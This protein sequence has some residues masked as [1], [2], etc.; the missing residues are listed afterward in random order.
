MRLLLLMRL[1]A[2]LA[3]AVAGG[4]VFLALANR[5]LIQLRQSRFKMFVVFSVMAAIIALSGLSGWVTGWTAWLAL[6][7]LVI[8]AA[9]A[10]EGFRFY[11]RA[12]HRASR[13]SER[14]RPRRGW[15]VLTTTDCVLARYA[16]ALKGWKGK[17][18]TIAHVSDLH[19]D[20]RLG[21]DYFR[22]VADR[23]V[24][25]QPDLL[26]IAGD[27]VPSARR[28]PLLAPVLSRFAPVPR[29]YA[30]LG[31]HDFWAG[32]ERVADAVARAGIRV[33]RNESVSLELAGGRLLLSGCEDPWGRPR[34]QAPERGRHD[35]LVVL[36]HTADVIYSLGRAGVDLAFSGH[37]HAGQIRIPF[38]G[39]VVVTSAFGRRFDHGHFK[40][41]PTDLYVSAGIGASNPPL[42]FFC[43]PDFF[44]VTVSAAAP[45]GG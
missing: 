3:W 5:V 26:L 36:V 27:F 19:V 42:R 31:N 16:L 37:Y 33:L 15:P 10:G 1:A 20:P 40:V 18:F 43:H 13:P 38:F 39:P 2:V 35:L 8:L 7:G 28:I 9:A 4:C 29:R 23:V 34:W 45:A 24:A 6:P 22:E 12:R 44:L 25:A 17:P 30:V 14:V 21:L 11:V 41:G 32:P